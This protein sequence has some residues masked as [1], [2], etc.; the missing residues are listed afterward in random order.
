MSVGLLLVTHENLGETLVKITEANLGPLALP[1]EVLPV[2]PDAETD[3]LKARGAA[4]L[5][6]LDRGKGVLILTDQ[7]GA[8]PSNL[9]HDICGSHC[10]VIHGLNLA[11]LLRAHTYHALDCQ[12]L[13][14]KI[15][16]GGHQAIF[17]GNQPG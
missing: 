12:E 15:V 16:E 2:A 3:Q 6:E 14:E 1:V 10:H 7:F 9:A 8:T 4:L 13:A 11:M 17:A 5:Q